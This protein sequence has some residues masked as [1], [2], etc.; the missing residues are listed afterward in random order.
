MR[1]EQLIFL[2]EDEVGS[3][4][5]CG[6]VIEKH[7]TNSENGYIMITLRLQVGFFALFGTPQEEKTYKNSQYFLHLQKFVVEFI[8]RVC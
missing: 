6:T 1:R 5:K 7:L 2:A 3:C 4:L 8:H